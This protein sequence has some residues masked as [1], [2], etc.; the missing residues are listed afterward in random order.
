[1]CY[2]VEKHLDV[3]NFVIFVKNIESCL[4]PHFTYDGWLGGL[5]CVYRPKEPLQEGDTNGLIQ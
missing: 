5:G 4:Y 3:K 1:M 2:A